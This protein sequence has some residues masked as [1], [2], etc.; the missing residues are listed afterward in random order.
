MTV[1]R[2]AATRFAA[3]ASPMIPNPMKPTGVIESPEHSPF[4]SDVRST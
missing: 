2:P 3:I 4:R 1:S